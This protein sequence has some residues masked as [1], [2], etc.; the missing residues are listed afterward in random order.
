MSQRVGTPINQV[1]LSNVAVVKYQ[2]DKKTF[3]VAAYPSKVVDFRNGIEVEL[4]EV[5]QVVTV[6]RNVSK[7]V[8]APM[9]EVKD[10]FGDAHT[11]CRVIL[12]QGSLQVSEKERSSKSEALFKEIAGIVADKT[13]EIREG[14]FTPLCRTRG[15]IRTRR[16]GPRF[17]EHRL[18]E[19]SAPSR[20]GAIED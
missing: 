17:R 7:G 13:L 15:D 18:R 11:A 6:F 5:L 20:A 4:D 8:I 9:K 19:T 3:E 10:V 1:K 12:M 14:R 16:H 2:K